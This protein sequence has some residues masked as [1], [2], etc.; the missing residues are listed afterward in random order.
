MRTLR[1]K[2]GIAPPPAPGD[3]GVA[4]LPALAGVLTVGSGV[5]LVPVDA[6]GLPDAAE[7]LQAATISAIGT[8]R[9]PAPRMDRIVDMICWFPQFAGRV[10]GPAR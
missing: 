8:R 10:A 6:A 3:A 1:S 9:A 4:S 7:P 5:P 2:D